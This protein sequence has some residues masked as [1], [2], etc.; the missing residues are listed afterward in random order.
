MRD[1]EKRRR[2]G[3][4]ASTRRKKR[5]GHTRYGKDVNLKLGGFPGVSEVT[6]HHGR[7]FGVARV[8]EPHHGAPPGLQHAAP[9]QDH[10][11]PLCAG[12]V[13]F[14]LHPSESK[15]CEIVR[16]HKSQIVDSL[17]EMEISF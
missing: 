16:N 4:G 17:L 12:L 13:A 8:G 14:H 6:V 7:N 9:K 3:G 2:V 11:P 1:G 5:A 10:V 15:A